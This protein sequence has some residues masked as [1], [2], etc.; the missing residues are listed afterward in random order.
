MNKIMTNNFKPLFKEK[1]NFKKFL[2]HDWLSSKIID[3]E[4]NLQ[5][6][7]YDISNDV[8][9]I[10]ENLLRDAL[11][12]QGKD[13]LDLKKLEIVQ[14]INLSYD[15]FGL[16][17][18]VV[19]SLHSLRTSRNNFSHSSEL[20]HYGPTEIDCANMLRSLQIVLYY[21]LKEIYQINI[22]SKILGSFSLDVYNIN[23]IE[24]IITE[25]DIKKVSNFSNNVIEDI[26]VNK[27]P[28]FSFIFS[29]I[30]KK[31]IV[32]IYQRG[33]DWDE[34]N[35][36]T[37]CDDILKRTKDDRSHYLG[38]IAVKKERNQLNNDTI[39]VKILDGQQRITTILLLIMGV[40]KYIKDNYSN[41]LDKVRMFQKIKEYTSKTNIKL[42]EIIDNPG[43]ASSLNNEFKCI[44]EEKNI[45]FSGSYDNNF[46]KIIS[47]LND[48]INSWAD[49]VDFVTV[50]EERLTIA[51]VDFDP[52]YITTKKE[53]EIF[54][55]LNS[56][57]KSLE[58]FD[59]I[60]NY[61]FNLCSN[62][63]LEKKERDIVVCFNT[64]IKAEFGS[65]TKDTKEFFEH[66]IMYLSGKEIKG[67]NK[68]ISTFKS[69]EKVIDQILNELNI[70]NNHGLD[71]HEFEN[72][73]KFISKYIK[74]YK[75]IK[76]KHFLYFQDYKIKPLLMS[77]QTK[78]LVPLYY[79]SFLINDLF[80]LNSLTPKDKKEIGKIYIKFIEY[81]TFKALI[82]SQGDSEPKRI[83]CETCH[84]A[85]KEF[86]KKEIKFNLIIDFINS[87]LKE[88]EKTKFDDFKTI[89][90][91]RREN[92]WATLTSLILMEYKI[93]NYL[94]DNISNMDFSDITLEHIMPQDVKE[95]NDNIID[96][97]KHYF[98]DLT[99]NN[100]TEYAS[101]YKNML[102]N[103]LILDKSKN[104]SI[105]NKKFNEKIDRYNKSIISNWK[106]YDYQT[107]EKLDIKNKKEWSFKN[108][109]ERTNFINE[110]FIK[111]LFNHFLN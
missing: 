29:E 41:N 48:N 1:I 81:L 98:S 96:W 31:F 102:G 54:E 43:G 36:R 84:Q 56:K 16:E 79:V 2:D 28:I 51:I 61:L 100:I 40:K 42:S 91:S 53:L 60:K 9:K 71:F 37:L 90:E 110:Y 69:F 3:C 20:S 18:Y 50:L 111:E 95:W 23:K 35:V 57:G 25:E 8:T 45:K 47:Y 10:L 64:H 103:F 78:K 17:S 75:E 86:I 44:L 83:I 80:E 32:P 4:N 38:V 106:T 19:S 67:K 93:S 11:L 62:E 109:E 58:S 99:L 85:R 97:N 108:I 89:L 88:K 5:N 92:D 74:I 21:F 27:I 49:I 66:F 76:G 104:S 82:T 14:L 33:Y 73:I 22:D 70:N 94:K 7:R 68:D 77:M 39:N 6:K 26:R 13:E 52:N 24:N 55:N 105:V 59:L 63:I 107:E 12:V 15:Q 30:K 87:K 65:N 46:L 34:E 101:R 72:V